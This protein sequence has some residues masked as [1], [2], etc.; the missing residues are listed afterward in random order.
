VLVEWAMLCVRNEIS[1]VNFW[2]RKSI[3]LHCKTLMGIIPVVYLQFVLATLY[4][5]KSIWRKA[6]AG[7][8]YIMRMS[9][10]CT[11]HQILLGWW[12]QED[13]MGRTYRT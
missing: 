13:E 10:I 2:R 1:F 5:F 7:R 3:R 12:N 6:G 9:I 11:L 4:G 8:N